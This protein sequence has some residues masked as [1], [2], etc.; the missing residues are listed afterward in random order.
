MGKS[1]KILC[2]IVLLAIVSSQTINL[3]DI[4]TNK[5]QATLGQ[6]YQDPNFLRTIDNY[7]GCKTWQNGN[8]LECSHGYIFNN[9]G[10]CCLIDRNC[11]IFNI[12]VGVCERCYTGFHVDANGTCTLRALS[13]PS[14]VGCAEWK[15]NQC[16]ACSALY[17]FNANGVCTAVSDQCRDWNRTTG[18]CTECYFGYIVQD[19][20]CVVDPSAP[21]S[22]D[23]K[24]NPLC[25]TWGAKGCEACA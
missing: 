8:C 13:D 11:E 21:L 4:F 19:G 17:Y 10:V 7:F 23:V 12:A 22:N 15:Q 6:E 20:N 18:A 14:L 25:H 1:S 3:N 2:V 9:N 24:A 16:V 5:T